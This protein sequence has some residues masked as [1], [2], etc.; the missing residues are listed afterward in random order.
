MQQPIPQYAP[1]PRFSIRLWGKILLGCGTLAL[2][3]FLLAA[4][5]LSRFVA[6]GRRSIQTT[7]CYQTAK[8][9]QRGLELYSQDYDQ[10]LPPAK[11]WMD[12]ATPFVKGRTDFRCPALRKSNPEGYGYAFNSKLAGLKKSK[13]KDQNQTMEVYDSTDLSRNASDPATSLPSPARHEIEGGR[14]GDHR[15]RD[16]NVVV[17][18]DGHVRLI[19]LTGAEGGDPV[20]AS[21]SKEL[22]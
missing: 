15:T 22:K 9:S 14:R 18:A 8:E 20:T 16:G 12:A 3:L 7:F 17:Y 2:L 4:F 6:S 1:P 10:T 11:T 19:G 13:I 21:A 5:G